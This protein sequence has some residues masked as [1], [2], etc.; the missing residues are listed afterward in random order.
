M[1]ARA[2]THRVKIICVLAVGCAHTSRLAQRAVGH[3]VA[4]HDEVVDA[5]RSSAHEPAD[6]GVQANRQAAVLH[7]VDG[8][9]VGGGGEEVR[10][11]HARLAKEQ[12]L[13]K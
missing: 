9:C 12:R 1:T 6:G 2:T 7:L 13:L 11:H 3:R 8:E 10:D 4:I 5:R